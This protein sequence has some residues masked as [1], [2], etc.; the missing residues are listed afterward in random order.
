M[1]WKNTE[2]IRIAKNGEVFFAPAGTTLPTNPTSTPA[3]GFVGAGFL[4]EDG[5]S[6]TFTPDIFEVKSWQA[7]SATRR[8][9]N[10]Q[11]IQAVFTFQQVNEET[12]PFALGGGEVTEVTEGVFRYDFIADG[13]S[14]DE[15]ALIIDA[16]DGEIHDRFVFARGNVTEAVEM[17]F[18]RGQEVRLPVTFKVLEPT[19]GGAPGYW[20]TDD[21]AFTEGS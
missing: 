4:T 16:I 14:L 13:D 10:G 21:P 17:T 5:A 6:V 15:R 9:L 1:S 19:T 7:R 20:L 2:E 12:L 3:S 8:D 11:D 18:Q